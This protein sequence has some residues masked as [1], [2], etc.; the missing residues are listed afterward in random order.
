MENSIL[1]MKKLFLIILVFSTTTTTLSAQNQQKIEVS[2]MIPPLFT[3]TL[4]LGIE[5]IP[6]KHFGTFINIGQQISSAPDFTTDLLSNSD[7]YTLVQ[8]RFYVLPK[9]GGDRCYIAPYGLYEYDK[10]DDE[11]GIRTKENRGILG[12]IIG[13]KYAYKSGLFLDLSLGLGKVFGGSRKVDNFIVEYDIDE[14]DYH[15]PIMLSLGFRF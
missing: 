15:T 12:G 3:S 4:N 13:Y 7:F 2:L 10:Y 5:Y 6:T 1:D 8:G 14:L 11:F 9:F